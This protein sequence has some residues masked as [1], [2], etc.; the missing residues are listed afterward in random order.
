MTRQFALPFPHAPQFAQAPF[1]RAESNAAALAWLDRTGDWPQRRL[2][3]WG[4][5][6][7]GKTHLLH[8]WAGRAG[9]TM[10]DGL[11]LT[12]EPP[13]GPMAIDDADTAPERPLLH[14]LNAAAEAGFPVALTGRA[15]P[16]RWSVRLPDLSSRLRAALA[17]E[18]GAP[19]D[20]LLRS[21]LARLLADRQLAVAEHVQDFL[22]LHLPRTPHALREAAARLDRLALASGSRITRSLAAAVVTELGGAEMAGNHQ[23]FTW[24]PVTASHETSTLL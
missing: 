13:A 1:L 11:A 17:V 3:L 22:L 18:I 21:L 14:L 4:A 5:E 19:E 20:S 9:A 10:V 16:S 7:R 2:V 8:R 15:P 24:N 23:D 6:G 12:L